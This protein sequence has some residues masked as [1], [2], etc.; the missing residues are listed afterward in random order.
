MGM[1]DIYNLQLLIANCGRPTA[2]C[3][4][5]IADRWPLIVIAGSDC[6]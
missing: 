6:D 2:D 5:L 3:W 4:P 1:G